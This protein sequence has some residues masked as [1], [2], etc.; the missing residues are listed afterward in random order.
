MNKSATINYTNCINSNKN[1][2]AQFINVLIPRNKSM[3]KDF[4]LIS[5]K[6]FTTQ[7]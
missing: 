3:T 6:P 7:K 4:N 2:F 5:N 1:I